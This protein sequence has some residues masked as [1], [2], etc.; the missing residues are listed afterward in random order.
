MVLHGNVEDEHPLVL[1]L[2]IE[3]VDQEL[4]IRPI[5]YEPE[6]SLLGRRRPVLETVE[7]LHTQ[8]RIYCRS[9]PSRSMIR[10]GPEHLVSLI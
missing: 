6:S 1:F 10:M 5:G 8:K 3:P 9:S 2:F 7:G 4:V